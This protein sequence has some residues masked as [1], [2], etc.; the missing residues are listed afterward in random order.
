M[1]FF[2][3]P[4]LGAG[5]SL[6]LVARLVD[7]TSA[8]PS[9]V[10]V[11]GRQRMLAVRMN[12]GTLDL[13]EG[14]AI[15]REHM[16]EAI[17]DFDSALEAF[18]EGGVVDE[19]DLPP[20]PE[21]VRPQLAE[22][23]ALWDRARPRLIDL[24]EHPHD[25]DVQRTRPEL[26]R[27]TEALLR[28]SD[29]LTS[30]IEDRST[31]LHD[32]MM[33]ALVLL[34]FLD[35]GLFVAGVLG[36]RR[37]LVAPLLRLR[38]AARKGAEGDLSVRVPVE[39]RDELASLGRSYNT[40]AEQIASLLDETEEQARCSK[41]IVQSL[42]LGVIVLDGDLRVTRT[43]E[44][45][46][47]IFDLPEDPAAFADD[48]LTRNGLRP[49]VRAI[50][51]GDRPQYEGTIDLE[52]GPG[53]NRRVRMI[54]LR[55][56]QPPGGEAPGVLLFLEDHTLE[57]RLRDRA[58]AQEE[59]FTSVVNHSNDAIV[60][61]DASGII[62]FSNRAAEE[63][64]GVPR[65]SLLGVSVEE[66]LADVG[67]VA[68]PA[69]GSEAG[70]LGAEGRRWD[71]SSFPVEGSVSTCLI[72]GKMGFTYVLRDVTERAESIAAMRR[73][74]DNL[75]GLI[76]GLPDAVVVESGERVVYVNR[77]FVEIWELDSNADVLGRPLSDFLSFEG[78]HGEDGPG[79][80]PATT[81]EVIIR[82]DGSR[83]EV[84]ISSLPLVFEGVPARLSVLRDISE[85]REL[86][87]RTMHVD[88]MV[89]IGTLAAGVGHEINNPLAYV[90]T[91]LS[92]VSEE[93][94]RIRDECL[95]C[96]SGGRASG[97]T[98]LTRRVNELH[99]AVREAKD[100]TK[101]VRTIV[102]DLKVLARNEEDD[103]VPTDLAEILETA[104]NMTRNEI[105]H[106]ATLVQAIEEL[107]TVLA[108]PGRLAQ[109]FVN[110]LM[111]AAQAIPEGHQLDNRVELSAT[112]DGDRVVVSVRDTGEG[113]PLEIQNRLYDPFF[114]TKPMG[115]GTGLGLSITRQIVES[116]GG[117]VSVQSVVGEG[118]VFRVTLPAAPTRRPLRSAPPLS[119]LGLSQRRARVLIVDDE[120]LVCRSLSRTLGREHDVVTCL[121]AREALGRIVGGERYDLI[122]CDLMMPEMTGM[123]LHEALQAH[124]PGV[125]REVIFFTGGAFTPGAK[126]FVEEVE[127][128]CLE[129]PVDI[130]ALRALVAERVT[131]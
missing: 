40:M 84:E 8:D 115:R 41:L 10:N 71:G 117:Q 9:F 83:M 3:V 73:A 91:N 43:N 19:H 107:P 24:A 63:L 31:A 13:A 116:V 93:L 21:E 80:T 86:A 1:L 128:L 30:A 81:E 97:G 114:T 12:T 53:D 112:S 6:F 11:S 27:E 35:L 96:A 34:I 62:D 113:I 120:E 82:R 15:P 67:S 111:N 105:R 52:I 47:R 17:H 48:V 78:A 119:K 121:D 23:R 44:T 38:D 106:R 103:R 76:E 85:R 72:R 65:G 55:T 108:N 130:A 56:P 101:R 22:V 90:M 69:R 25:A 77:P 18:S 122:L 109:V 32:Q 102:R 61:T 58:A 94:G 50:A 51:S 99:T 20:A 7:Q 129:K 64:F 66:F 92:H 79:A 14:Q 4:V 118:T 39:G 68:P 131:A 37:F 28:A 75:Q 5:I 88:R 95:E 123:E 26:Q 59:R 110:L 54:A 29:R 100:G 70:T 126:H 89:A 42:P 127:N 36:V 60:M 125:A 124:D 74:A 104:V 16:L 98:P 2:L 45:F 33:L 49:D 57:D 87:A 46:S